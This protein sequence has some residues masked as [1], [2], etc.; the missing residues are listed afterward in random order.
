MVQIFGLEFISFPPPPN[1]LGA[2]GVLSMIKHRG[3]YLCGYSVKNWQELEKALFD[4]RLNSLEIPTFILISGH[5]A[6]GKVALGRE[7]ILLADVFKANPGLFKGSWVHLSYCQSL[8]LSEEHRLDLVD[9]YDLYQ[10][11]G[12][13][14]QPVWEESYLLDLEVAKDFIIENS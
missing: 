11:S 5:G 14:R 1:N 6:D 10:L 3:A 2:E 13:K 12:Y 8:T 7:E 9:K 4:F